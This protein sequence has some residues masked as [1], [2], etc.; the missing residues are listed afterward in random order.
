MKN[1][2]AWETLED[3]GIGKK[4]TKNRAVATYVMQGGQNDQAKQKTFVSRDKYFQRSPQKWK[5]VYRD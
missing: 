2:L 1:A 4:K 3:T 5:T